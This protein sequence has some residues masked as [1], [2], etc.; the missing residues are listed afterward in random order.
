MQTP[1]LRTPYNYDMNAAGDE[2]GIS[3][4]E[5]TLAKQEFKEETDINTIVERFHITG[6]LPENVR[7]PTHQDFL[8]IFDFQD[9]MNAIVQAREAFQ[10]MPA[11]VRYRFHND[12][13]EFVDFCSDPNNKAELGKLGL[14]DAA[15]AEALAAEAAAKTAAV[16]P[17]QPGAPLGGV[18]TPPPPRVT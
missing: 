15:R 10:Q 13:A 9:A 12:P 14:I 6:E 11:N 16:A 5:P 2:D 17:G 1:F 18:D 8:G 3:C 4:P 7:A